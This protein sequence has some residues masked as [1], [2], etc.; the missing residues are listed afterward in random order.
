MLLLAVDVNVRVVISLMIMLDCGFFDPNARSASLPTQLLC[1]ADASDSGNGDSI[2]PA[3]GFDYMQTRIKSQ[4]ATLL[5]QVYLN[6]LL[7]DS[8]LQMPSSA[9]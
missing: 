1:S 5:D 7:N 8:L 6:S 2:E 9:A 3:E 4:Q